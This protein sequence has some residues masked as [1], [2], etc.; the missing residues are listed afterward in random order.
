M[1]KLY[2]LH[3]LLDYVINNTDSEFHE[4]IVLTQLEAWVNLLKVIKPKSKDILEQKD[5]IKKK[6]AAG[7]NIIHLYPYSDYINPE[8]GEEMGSEEI[9]KIFARLRREVGSDVFLAKAIENKFEL[10]IEPLYNRSKMK[11]LN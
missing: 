4:N 11:E 2:W 1:T 9:D 6:S 8:T 3:K 5:V 7:S 10:E